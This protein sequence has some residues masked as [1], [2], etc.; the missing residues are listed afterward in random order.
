MFPR[1]CQ[2]A[3]SVNPRTTDE[4]VDV[5]EQHR[6]SLHDHVHCGHFYNNFGR[7]LSQMHSTPA[8][9]VFPSQSRTAFF[10]S[11]ASGLSR[12]GLPLNWYP[13][14]AKRYEMFPVFLGQFFIVRPAEGLAAHPFLFK[15]DFGTAVTKHSL[16]T[17]L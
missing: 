1:S 2:R 3:A 11:R 10:L 12:L 5:W 9:A 7:K 16:I 8:T 15:R 6:R 13:L 14:T 17:G 4:R